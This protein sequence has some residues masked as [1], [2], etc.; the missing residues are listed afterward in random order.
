MRYINVHFTYLLTYL[1][2]KEGHPH[3]RQASH[4]LWHLRRLNPMSTHY[5]KILNPPLLTRDNRKALKCFSPNENDN[6]LVTFA[7]FIIVKVIVVLFCPNT[8]RQNNGT[9]NSAVKP[10]SKAT[11]EPNMTDKTVS[12]P[13]PQTPR[14][15]IHSI[16][17]SI[18]PLCSVLCL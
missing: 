17:S 8:T 1:P 11:T 15:S 6:E 13:E 2:M 7:F 12:Y 3:L 18:L 10:N 4:T 16:K 14:T 5:S 9:L